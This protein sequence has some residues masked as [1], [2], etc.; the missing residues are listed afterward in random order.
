ML[1][2]V[3]YE[4]RDFHLG[5]ISG[6]AMYVGSATSAFTHEIALVNDG[7]LVSAQ[8]LRGAPVFPSQQ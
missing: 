6:R 8:G 5:S 1:R 2:T 3:N 4:L 7:M